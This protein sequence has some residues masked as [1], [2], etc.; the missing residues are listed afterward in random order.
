MTELMHRIALPK[1]LLLLVLAVLV[2]GCGS[3]LVRKGPVIPAKRPIDEFVKEDVRY[4][5]DA[6]DPLEGFNRRIYK[7]NA[8]FDEY[9]FLPVVRG[10]EFIT[11]D[12]I[13][14]MISNFFSNLAEI[15]TLTNSLLQFKG[16]KI[17]KTTG[18][19]II[20]TTVGIAGLFDPATSMSFQ[21][22]DEDFGQTLGFYG[23]GNGPY[24]I[25]P[26]LGPSTFRDTAGIAVDTFVYNFVLNE[27]IDELGMR[28]S[29]EDLLRLS[30]FVVNAIDTRHNQSFRYYE[31]GSPF[32]YELI[33]LLYLKKRLLQIE[34]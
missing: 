20:N 33:R 22:Q 32:E 31:T 26:I 21:R 9:V 12:F 34:H 2:C 1:G 23:L 3:P 8:K 29:E 13:E 24:L 18:R 19:I 25:L 15:K 5:I 11:P 27:I 7:F 16:Q 10:Y 6:Y 17:V 30:L 4:A 14:D 28:D